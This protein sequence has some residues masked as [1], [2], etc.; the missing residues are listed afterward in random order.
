VFQNEENYT[1]G[2]KTHQAI[3]GAVSFFTALALTL[4]IVLLAL[5]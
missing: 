3:S 1:F 4:T 5:G 2:Y